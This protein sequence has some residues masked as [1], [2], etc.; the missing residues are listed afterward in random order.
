MTGLS[1]SSYYYQAKEKDPREITANCDL[2]DMIE[3]IVLEFA[4]YGYRRVTAQLHREGVIAN[5]KKVLKLI[6]E[7]S[8]LVVYAGF[9]QGFLH[10]LFRFLII[11]VKQKT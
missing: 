3:R 8:L 9:I 10:V 5:H 4:G 6:W 2:M 11:R 1:R 7:S